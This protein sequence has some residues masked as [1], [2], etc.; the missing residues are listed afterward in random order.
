MSRNPPSVLKPVPKQF[1]PA[2]QPVRAAPPAAQVLRT[3]R[4]SGLQ[5]SFQFHR[6][7]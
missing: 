4:A 1:T 5:L 3:T 6:L 7:P 2:R